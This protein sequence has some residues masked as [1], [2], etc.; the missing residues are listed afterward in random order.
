MHR[1]CF[2]NEFQVGDLAEADKH[3]E[4]K[5][6]LLRDRFRLCDSK[7]RLIVPLCLMYRRTCLAH[8]SARDA[9]CACGCTCVRAWS[10]KC[11]KPAL[12]S[13]RLACNES[14][15]RDK[16]AFKAD[17]APE[18]IMT[19]LKL[20][21]RKDDVLE[22]IRSVLQVMGKAR[23]APQFMSKSDNPCGCNIESICVTFYRYNRCAVTLFRDPREI[24]EYTWSDDILLLA[25]GG[26]TSLISRFRRA[27]QGRRLIDQDYMRSCPQTREDSTDRTQL[28]EQF[29]GDNIQ[30][31][32][33]TRIWLLLS[34]I[35]FVGSLHAIPGRLSGMWTTCFSRLA[36]GVVTASPSGGWSKLF[37]AISLE[38]NTYT[39]VFMKH[40]FVYNNSMVRVL[41]GTC[42][43][44]RAPDCGFK[45]K[46]RSL[47]QCRRTHRSAVGHDKTKPKLDN[48]ARPY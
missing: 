48:V 29:C 10:S 26:P 1:E 38:L 43:S 22:L 34:S 37:N 19:L 40:S 23:F 33:A 24:R 30:D 7:A 13:L 32:M 5:R 36:S 8:A 2:Q 4:T 28:L 15:L 27:R 31:D 35:L 9:A 39:Y 14:L 12:Q 42:T 21:Y 41:R 18:K 46:A 45:R 17:N 11:I 6:A 3:L 16:F 20:L 25:A 44:V 47:L